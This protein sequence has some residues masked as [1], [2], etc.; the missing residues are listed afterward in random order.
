MMCDAFGKALFV[1]PF[2]KYHVLHGRSATHVIGIDKVEKVYSVLRIPR[3]DS[4]KS[5]CTDSL[6]LCDGV[7]RFPLSTLD[8]RKREIKKCGDVVEIAAHGL[9]GFIQFLQGH[10]LILITKQKIVGK[11]GH[12]YIFSIE[13][14]MLLPLF[15]ETYHPHEKALRDQFSAM[16]LAKDFYFSYTYELSRTAQQNLADAK[17]AMNGSERRRPLLSE[18][19]G[20]RHHRF[21][22][23]HY[24]LQPLLRCEGWQHWCFSIVHGF[25]SYT[26]C[27]SFGWTFDIVLIA[28]R[29]RFYAGTRYRK[30]GINV[31]G[32]VANDVETEQ[33][34]CDDS[35]RH[36]HQG[37]VMSFVQIRGSVPLFWSQEVT[38]LSPKPP[39]QYPSCDPTLSAS[40]F[41]FADLLERYCTPVIAVNLMKA[42]KADSGEARLG[43]HMESVIEVINRELPADLRV[44]Y[45]P[46]D[47]KNHSKSRDSHAHGGSSGG[48]IY[49]VFQRLAESVVSR[50][51]FFHTWKG[52]D[53]L[54]ERTQSGV[55]RTNCV[56]CLDRT[57]V[58]QF[59]VGL[60]ALKRQLAALNLLP[61]PR[62]DTESHIVGVLSELYDL[63]GD[64]LALQYAGSV[65]HKKY[66][67]LGHRSR[68]MNSSKELFT[69]IQRHYSNSFTDLSRQT[70]MNLFLGIHQGRAM[71]LRAP[72][73]TAQTRE[74]LEFRAPESDSFAHHEQ[75]LDDYSPGRW[76]ELPLRTYA[77]KNDVLASPG[78]QAVVPRLFQTAG[79][80]RHAWF[81]E[82]HQA[83]KLTVFD[84]DPAMHLF[85]EVETTQVGNLN[86]SAKSVAKNSTM[87][88]ALRSIR[89]FESHLAHSAG[90]QGREPAKA[91]AQTQL[92]KELEELEDEAKRWP[93][94]LHNVYQ[95]V[96]SAF[97]DTRVWGRLLWSRQCTDFGEELLDASCEE[98]LFLS[99][100]E[101]ASCTAS[102]AL[103]SLLKP[104]PP[105]ATK[106]IQHASP[107]ATPR[108]PD[109]QPIASPS[110]SFHRRFLPF[111][112]SSPPPQPLLAAPHA[113]PRRVRQPSLCL[114]EDF[115][116]WYLL[117]KDSYIFDYFPQ[118]HFL[119][120][121]FVL[122]QK[123]CQT[124]DPKSQHG[125]IGSIANRTSIRATSLPREPV[126][127]ASIGDG[128]A[129]QTAPEALSK[130]SFPRVTVRRPQHRLR[131]C[132]YCGE[133]FAGKGCSDSSYPISRRSPSNRTDPRRSTIDS[134][135]VLEEAWGQG[136][137]L[138]KSH[139]RRAQALRALSSAFYGGGLAF[140]APPDNQLHPSSE[141]L[142]G[143]GQEESD[144]FEHPV[145]PLKEPAADPQILA[146]G[147]FRTSQPGS[148][149]WEGWLE[150]AGQS[151]LLR[152]HQDGKGVNVH[153]LD[154]DIGASPVHDNSG[155]FLESGNTPLRRASPRADSGLSKVW[156]PA[157][158]SHGR[159]ASPRTGALPETECRSPRLNP[160]RSPLDF[161]F[162]GI[163]QA[164]EPILS[165]GCLPDEVAEPSWRHMWTYGFPHDIPPPPSA[166]D[167]G[168]PDW[169]LPTLEPPMASASSDEDGEG[170][171]SRRPTHSGLRDRSRPKSKRQS[172][173]QQ[174]KLRTGV[175]VSEL[176]V[177]R[178]SL[179]AGAAAGPAAVSA[180]TATGI[181]GTGTSEGWQAED[182]RWVRQRQFSPQL[183]PQHHPF[184]QQPH[185]PRLQPMSLPQP[186]PHSQQ[187]PQQ[188]QQSQQ[189]QQ[190]QQ[191][192]QNQQAQQSLPSP[193]HQ[194]YQ[195]QQP[196]PQQTL[197]QRER[198]GSHSRKTSMIGVTAAATTAPA[199]A[200]AM[201]V[202]ATAAAAASVPLTGEQRP[203]V[204]LNHGGPSRG[205]LGVQVPLSSPVEKADR[206]RENSPV[207]DASFPSGAASLAQRSVFL[208]IGRER[209]ARMLDR[210]N[211]EEMGSADI[212]PSSPAP[213][214]DANPPSRGLLSHGWQPP[215]GGQH[216]SS[217]VPQG[218]P[219]PPSSKP[220]QPLASARPFWGRGVSGLGG[221]SVVSSEDDGSPRPTCATAGSDRPGTV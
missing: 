191:S 11:I 94:R 102:K 84:N 62:L 34:L 50:T 205:R 147:P 195:Q 202:A 164:S 171:R 14:T 63:M 59:F 89:A 135:P 73:L 146:R 187:Q 78:A 221:Q 122:W 215:E 125:R 81:R 20:L 136:L 184:P 26:K 115:F 153:H 210:V 55:L 75:L 82:V 156:S 211:Q 47:V 216:K 154:D 138:C 45:R 39:V 113:K 174:G 220:M 76:W 8:Q 41:H 189:P 175:E 126:R 86:P 128:M 200:A 96:Y 25:F 67:L 111:A 53:G 18:T 80:A 185:H 214:H 9:V 105:P 15:D 172:Y 23:N 38:A 145:L 114:N 98:L 12:H 1:Q 42:K 93:P 194:Q 163:D 4:P 79:E 72:D 133:P 197:Q 209:L 64:H 103:M 104:P 162:G 121:W 2:T 90:S 112:S 97:A 149:Q 165:A 181:T 141:V 196:Q 87:L 166:Q 110:T 58:L 198:V 152:L 159:A 201:L 32:H 30:R 123:L 69:S 120:A 99:E 127:E 100:R 180:A 124:T 31:H 168:L 10:Y 140:P 199:A 52:V 61:E 43:K 33:L 179:P 27:S 167:L 203:R 178:T 22:W 101:V 160:R 13:D 92:L 66:Q 85:R 5:T 83:W 173:Q 60:E 7:D 155:G 19:D 3:R 218:G 176:R 213:R 74:L 150:V 44:V 212:L 208:G 142:H 109:V 48:S 118:W 16:N 70:S 46:F 139:T 65:V 130:K 207:I 132:A 131:L 40:R 182:G 161:G 24:H 190:L 29:S 144:R 206:G 35:T 37:H 17:R 77:A 177:P 51:N 192:Q 88:S 137:Q 28:R 169:W 119:R 143:D 157:S 148:Q 57:N 108:D 6:H 106:R 95:E 204:R 56:D 217:A 188:T 68:M 116:H 193:Q 134:S 219:P 170:I 186:Q 183:S 107:V 71:R 158:V 54:P 36:M 117:S 91:K 49:D 129:T 21:T 151:R